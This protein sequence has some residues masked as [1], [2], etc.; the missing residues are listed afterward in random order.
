MSD[1]G[2][3]FFAGRDRTGG[4][5]IGLSATGAWIRSLPMICQ[6]YAKR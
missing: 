2:H 6:A 1:I 3:A 5:A 4:S